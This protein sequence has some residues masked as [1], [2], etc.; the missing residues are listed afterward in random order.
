MAPVTSLPAL[1]VGA[2]SALI[3]GLVDR[4]LV[5]F[6]PGVVVGGGKKPDVF[7]V[8]L[9]RLVKFSEGLPPFCAEST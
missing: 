6:L 4:E 3:D 2:L 1:K 8:E 5:E 9:E 7:I